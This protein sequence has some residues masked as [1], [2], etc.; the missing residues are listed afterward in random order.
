MADRAI[1]F[2]INDYQGISDLR[3]CKNDVKNV[4]KLLEQTYGFE[5]GNIK[6]W[7]DQDVVRAKIDEQFD[8]L[9]D[10]AQ[11]GDRLVFHF[12]GHGSFVES[13]DSDEALD[14]LI[15]LWDM[16]WDNPSTY[17]IDD[18]LGELTRKAPSGARLTVIL[19]A[20][21]SGT[22]TRTVT[23]DLGVPSSPTSRTRMLIADAAEARSAI[24]G[25]G[26][27]LQAGDQ[28]ALDAL[29]RNEVPL[30]YARFV[31]PPSKH[32]RSRGARVVR[33]L[34][35]SR[36][37]LN[38]QLLA[39]AADDQTAADAF[40]SG[41]YHG[42]FSYYLCETA[43]RL[44]RDASVGQVMGGTTTTIKEEGYSQVPQ[45]EGP[46]SKEKLFGGEAP[47]SPDGPETP[48]PTPPDTPTS[49]ELAA[50]LLAIFENLLQLLRQ[51]PLSTSSTDPVNI[52]GGECVVFVHGISKHRAGYSEAW[53]NSMRPYISSQ[54][55][56]AEVLWSQH[57][58]RSI[59]S[60]GRDRTASWTAELEQELDRRVNALERRIPPDS[61]HAQRIERPRG[62]RFASDD[63]ARYMLNR[64]T[65]D[66]ILREFDMVVRPLLEAGKKVHIVS[67]SWGTVVAYEGMRLL[68]DAW[69]Q[70]KVA[71]LF[72]V[73]SALSIR[74]VRSNLFGRVGDGRLPNHVERIINVDAGGDIV[75]G[76][77]GNYFTTH[78]EYLG[79]EPVG[80]WQV[81]FTNIA[82]NPVCAHSSYFKPANEDVNNDIFARFINRS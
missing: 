9:V 35:R 51:T 75:G 55:E 39:G 69:L 48:T 74:M 21:H 64:A 26:R 3:G 28:D 68:D 16:D 7:F 63:F 12:S 66:D 6:S 24:P 50:K 41:N 77:I 30:A 65:R 31:L 58:N 18:D 72:V 80:C 76:P 45:N 57:V 70:S 61:R 79:V 17:L 52:R 11:P 22:G 15:C 47:V 8:W 32:V 73:G 19:D 56:R 33:R 67:H 10:G 20:C 71:N 13:Q 82:Y 5:Q 23:H 2:G 29:K 81:P 1:L 46:F 38:H 4:A 78:R 44:G 60:R 40:I 34:R 25:L 43:R 36:A 49:P 59:S 54:I 14:E 37:A 62:E 42:A 53:F 27:R